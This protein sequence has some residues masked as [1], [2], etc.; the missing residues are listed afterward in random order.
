VALYIVMIGESIV[1]SSQ[2]RRGSHGG[3]AIA[4]T[5]TTS[6][7][8]PSRSVGRLHHTAAPRCLISHTPWPH[9][10]EQHP[11][12]GFIE[13]ASLSDE[14]A[15][16]LEALRVVLKAQAPP[17]R[18]PPVAGGGVPNVVELMPGLW[19]GNGQGKVA[20]ALR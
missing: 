6:L 19:L 7:Q 16:A 20:S 1:A 2:I 14:E 5:A 12:L 9:A 18:F 8:S 3:A 13:P 11:S 17:T 15:R 4:I 10:S